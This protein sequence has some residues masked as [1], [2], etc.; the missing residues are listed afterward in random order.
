LHVFGP[1]RTVSNQ[2]GLSTNTPPVS[3]RA[4]TTYVPATLPHRFQLT[5]VDLPGFSV[6]DVLPVSLLLETY[7]AAGSSEA[8][9][10]RPG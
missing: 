9:P 5:A 3:A 7:V 2:A 6:K 4:S 8:D 1:A 10:S